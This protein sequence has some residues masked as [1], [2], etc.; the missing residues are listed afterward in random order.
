MLSSHPN[1]GECMSLKSILKKAGAYDHALFYLR[2]T[3]VHYYKKRIE[4]DEKLKVT[5]DELNRAGTLGT[6]YGWGKH[7][8]E[9][10]LFHLSIQLA[11]IINT[12]KERL[13]LADPNYRNASFL[14]AGDPDRIVLRSIGSERGV[15]LNIM[16]DCLK[17]V[18]G[19]GGFPVKGD[20]Q[21]MSFRNKSFDYVLCFETLEH[22][23]N[24]ILGLKELARVSTKKVFISIPWVEK[25]SIH[26]DNYAPDTPAVENHVFEFSREDFAKIITHADLKITYYKEIN[27]FPNIS[28]PFHNFLFKRF[29]YPGFFP[30]IQFYELTKGG[31]NA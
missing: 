13:Q 17:Q 23:E 10:V 15:S 12:L 26:E 31:A 30:K 27:I 24:P 9:F 3:A 7:K 16:D 6:H 29:Y 11:E 20:I 14:D 8:E 25:T 21:M 28:N 1:L 4:Q 5:I 2:K 19:V 18:K 22:L